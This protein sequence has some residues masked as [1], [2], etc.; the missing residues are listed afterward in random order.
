[1]GQRQDELEPPSL[2]HTMEEIL[3]AVIRAVAQPSSTVL[4]SLPGLQEIT[5]AMELLQTAP[6][7][8]APGPIFT[9][10]TIHASLP[11]E[12]L[13]D[14]ARRA[15]PDEKKAMLAS[16]IAESGITLPDVLTAVDLGISRKP[17]HEDFLGERMLSDTW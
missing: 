16:S 4:V 5:T 14:A 2:D 10:C 8:G 6:Q 13:E 12:V 7:S 15:R 3:V 1:M 9:K 11:T 17:A